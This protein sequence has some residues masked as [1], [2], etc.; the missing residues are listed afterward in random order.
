MRDKNGFLDINDYIDM[1]K[2]LNGHVKSYWLSNGE[3][4]G[5]FK[6]VSPNNLYRELLFPTILKNIKVNTVVNDL[7]TY[8]NSYGIFSQ[9]Y[10]ASNIKTYS[11]MS[12]SEKYCKEILRKTYN[13]EQEYELHNISDMLNILKWVC[14]T[15]NITF[16]EEKARQELFLK[17]IMQILLADI[18]NNT[19]N[20]EVFFDECLEF[21][22]FFDF[23]YYGWARVELSAANYRFRFY[24]DRSTEKPMTYKE[25][26]NHFK[27]YA[28][29]KEMETFMFYLKQ[30]QTLK[31]SAQY[32]EI[33]AKIHAHIPEPMKLKLK[34]DYESNLKNVDALIN[35]KK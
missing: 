21:S 16:L 9:S 18:D 24:T 27:N 30:L 10:H 6:F 5:V 31:I 33:E 7:A 28:T 4:E 29:K 8:H 15:N 26:I 14:T 23:E 20:Q 11:F 2:K 12:L 32:E 19:V 34:K 35:D 17:F 3:Q 22:P 13:R 1:N 25:T